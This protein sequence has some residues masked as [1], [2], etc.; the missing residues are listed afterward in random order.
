MELNERFEKAHQSFGEQ[1]RMEKVIPL[2]ESYQIRDL[3]KYLARVDVHGPYPTVPNFLVLSSKETYWP[4]QHHLSVL[5]TG[6]YLRTFT[7]RPQD[8]SIAEQQGSGKLIIINEDSVY[9]S[10]E[11]DKIRKFAVEIQLEKFL[12]R[13]FSNSANGSG[14]NKIVYN[15]EKCLEEIRE[16]LYKLGA[17]KIG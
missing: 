6:V 15:T 16:G 8:R 7:G 3:E 9:M 5:P 13:P 4:S 1:K 17:K 14:N 11:D 12:K 10:N 2:I